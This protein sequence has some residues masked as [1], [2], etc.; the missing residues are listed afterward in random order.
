MTQLHRAYRGECPLLLAALTS[1]DRRAPDA[2]GQERPQLPD[3]HGP[4][5]PPYPALSARAYALI[6]CRSAAIAATI[7]ANRP[8]FAHRALVP[9]A[10]C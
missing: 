2:I 6:N 3:L 4:H 5:A 8:K 10:F 7:L 9:I 1:T